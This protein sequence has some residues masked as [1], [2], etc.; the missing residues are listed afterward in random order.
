ML[1]S[2]YQFLALPNK[3]GRVDGIDELFGNHT[4]GPDHVEG[5]EEEYAANGYAALAKYDANGDGFIDAQDPI[6]AKLRLWSDRNQ[7]GVGTPSELNSLAS[8][9]IKRLD[10]HFVNDG[11]QASKSKP[12]EMDDAGNAAKMKSV[13]EYTDPTKAPGLMFD[14][15]FSYRLAH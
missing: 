5:T 13:F 4:L 6:F 14:L 8:F 9:G 12:P 10:L 7:D 15:W 2:N 11:D 1:D 3:F